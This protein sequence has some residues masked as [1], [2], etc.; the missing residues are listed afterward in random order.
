MADCDD[1]DNVLTAFL[2][3]LDCT[4]LSK[5]MPALSRKLEKEGRPALLK[6]LKDEHS[7]ANLSQRQQVAN[8]LGRFLR[9]GTVLEPTAGTRFLCDGTVLEPSA[10][11]T[12]CI[13]G[14][15]AFDPYQYAEAL[16][17]VERALPGRTRRPRSMGDIASKHRILGTPMDPPWPEPHRRVILAA[18]CFWSLEKGLWRLP[19]VMS[20]AVGYAFGFTPHPSYSEV[21]TGLTGHTE[22]VQCVYDPERISLADLL[23]WFYECHDPCQGMG[24]GADRGTQYRSAIKTFDD[25]QHALATA[26][27]GAYQA[28][29]RGAGGMRGAKTLTVQVEAASMTDAFFMAEEYHRVSY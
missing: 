16:V 6:A 8:A 15:F 20:T 21:C 14:P 17:P 10:G 19:G 25:E 7:I 13:A 9:D 28:A 12:D 2:S 23:R 4:H 3:K 18:G 29:I 22:A 5:L 11:T 26:S 24:Q 27:L 1:A